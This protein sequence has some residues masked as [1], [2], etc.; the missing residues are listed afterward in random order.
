MTS[1][2]S[3]PSFTS[4]YFEPE[5]TSSTN[6]LNARIQDE[7]TAAMNYDMNTSVQNPPSSYSHIQY[8]ITPTQS[9]LPGHWEGYAACDSRQPTRM[10]QQNE[11]FRGRETMNRSKMRASA[12]FTCLSSME[13]ENRRPYASKRRKASEPWYRKGRQKSFDSSTTSTMTL[14]SRSTSTGCLSNPYET[15]DT[16]YM[17]DNIDENEMVGYSI[18]DFPSSSTEANQ[19]K[20]LENLDAMMTIQASEPQSASVITSQT[21]YKSDQNQNCGR[22]QVTPI[23]EEGSP[24]SALLQSI[25]L[26]DL[27][28]EMESSLIMLTE[29]RNQSEDS[30]ESKRSVINTESNSLTESIT[31]RLACVLQAFNRRNSV[32]IKQSEKSYLA[33]TTLFSSARCASTAGSLWLLL[34]SVKCV[35]TCDISGCS[36]MKRVINHCMNCEAPLG[37]CQVTCDEAKAILLHYGSCS[38]REDARVCPVCSQLDEIEEAHQALKSKNADNLL[39]LAASA[40]NG[41]ISSKH[42]P[43]QPNLHSQNSMTPFVCSFALYLEQ[44][45]PSFRA[46]LNAR[47]EKRVTAS[48]SQ[49]LIQHMQKKTRLRSLDNIRTESRLAALA[50]MERELYLYMQTASLASLGNGTPANQSKPW[51]H[52]LSAFA[53]HSA[54][55]SG[56]FASVPSYLLNGTAASS[57]AAFFAQ[58]PTYATYSRNSDSS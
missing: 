8:Q 51:P 14:M 30:W 50:E 44:S 5:G 1:S 11:E 31:S 39:S 9:E 32:S 38:S 6:M 3:C 16:Y 18:D 53:F 10:R 23:D 21:S 37:N 47:V 12:S 34:H 27:Q 24:M 41:S 45:C 2:T 15:P 55:S 58:H 25:G 33:K 29:N 19:T 17:E 56:F 35:T 42:V 54:N 28:D 26:V 4:L 52:E 57:L 7:W 40:P 46:E 48:A 43:I 13:K 20:K 22:T 36:T 49:N